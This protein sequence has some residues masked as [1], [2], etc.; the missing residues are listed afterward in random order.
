[1]R[2]KDNHIQANLPTIKPITKHTVIQKETPQQ[3]HSTK[4]TVEQQEE[5]DP[6]HLD[7]SFETHPA[8]VPPMLK[9]H[10]VQ[11]VLKMQRSHLHLC[12]SDPKDAI[13]EKLLL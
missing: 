4:Q 6:S 11:S 7:P 9:E 3:F 13:L 2:I 5:V 10:P 12:P 8:I 1:M